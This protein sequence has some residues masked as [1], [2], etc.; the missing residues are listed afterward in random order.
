MRRS[1]WTRSNA[2]RLGRTRNSLSFGL[3]LS[4]LLLLAKQYVKI[5]RAGTRDIKYWTLDLISIIRNVKKKLR[6]RINENLHDS[7]Y[8][9]RKLLNLLAIR[10]VRVEYFFGSGRVRW[11]N[12][13]FLRS[14][15]RTSSNIW[16][17]TGVRVKIWNDDILNYLY[18]K[19]SKLRI[20]KWRKMNYSIVSLSNLYFYFL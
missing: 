3:L 2:V 18:F 6:P 12:F 14:S 9:W 16:T 7:F 11:G 1:E 19:I 17:P 10:G 4:W 8:F 15:T 5:T 13:N 20:L